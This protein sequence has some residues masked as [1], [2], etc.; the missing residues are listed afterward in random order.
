MS[1]N[2][3]FEIKAA[4]EKKI[5][6]NTYFTKTSMELDLKLE[7]SAKSRPFLNRN[8]KKQKHPQS[9]ACDVYPLPSSITSQPPLPPSIPV[10]KDFHYSRRSLWRS[11]SLLRSGFLPTFPTSPPF[12]RHKSDASSGRSAIQISKVNFMF[13]TT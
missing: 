1:S 8:E 5:C 7:L 9:P 10:V 12:Q 13:R 4:K 2:H 3:L 11:H 6:K